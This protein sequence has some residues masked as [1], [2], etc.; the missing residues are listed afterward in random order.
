M[1][2]VL[3]SVPSEKRCVDSCLMRFGHNKLSFCSCKNDP[4]LMKHVG[5]IKGKANIQIRGH[6]LHKLF[7]YSYPTCERRNAEN[8]VDIFHVCRIFTWKNG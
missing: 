5:E 6:C 3:L 2:I 4:N 7:T 1:Y 8:V